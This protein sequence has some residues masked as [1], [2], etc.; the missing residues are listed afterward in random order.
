M[1]TDTDLKKIKKLLAPLA[2]KRDDGGG[3]NFGALWEK[4]VAI[5]IK[6]DKHEKLIRELKKAQV[7]EKEKEGE[8]PIPIMNLP[9][10]YTAVQ[11]DDKT[12]TV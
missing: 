10:H 1:L 7:S 6:L 12:K 8:H 3:K 9:M 5:K 11:N 4:Y 2:T